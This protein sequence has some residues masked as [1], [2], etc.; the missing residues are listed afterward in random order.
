[1]CCAAGRSTAPRPRWRPARSS[2]SAAGCRVRASAS[3]AGRACAAAATPPAPRPVTPHPPRRPSWVLVQVGVVGAGEP[4]GEAI[5]GGLELGVEVDERLQPV[6]Q[7]GER[8]LL[9]APPVDQLLDAAIGRV[10]VGLV[11]PRTPRRRPR[12]AAPRA[13]GRSRWPA[14][15]R[16]G[17]PARSAA[18][19][20][21][22][23]PAAGT[24]RTSRRPCSLAAP[25]PTAPRPTG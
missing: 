21:R 17:G 4:G 14:R 2:R 16:P 10:H 12:A 9:L 13:P 24:P 3:G 8:D 15:R 18:A 5:D 23:A 7:P 1:A 25:A 6:G 19:A 22:A 20:R 11:S